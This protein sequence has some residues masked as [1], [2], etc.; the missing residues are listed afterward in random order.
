MSWLAV[1]RKDFQDSARS[2][3]LW[4]VLAVFVLFAGGIA[5]LYGEYLV[6][7]LSGGAPPAG[8]LTLGFVLLMSGNILGGV[9]PVL[10]LV[11]IIGL[12]LGYKSVV[13]ERETGQIKLLLG[14][15]HSRSDVVLGKL[16]G[17]TAVALL[18]VG[19]GFLVA[20][21]VV[22]IFGSFSPVVYLQF[23]VA[24]AIFAFVHVSIGVGI[25]SATSSSSLSILGIVA[26]VGIFQVVWGA[27]FTVGQFV[28][29]DIT[30]TAPDWYRFLRNVT[31]G[32]AYDGL[33]A[34]VVPRYAEAQA[35]AANNSPL[36]AAGDQ[37]FFLQDWFGVLLLVFWGTV[38]LAL[39][40][41]RFKSVDLG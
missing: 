5:F 34:T 25:S 10:V 16:A 19:V 40:Y 2:K 13:G 32:R 33:L 21:V 37:P 24:V 7:D 3:L 28:L 17:R 36:Q 23:V 27:A 39:G 14:L 15:P 22:A 26:F 38:P 31:P 41:L 20:A 11:P 9:G 1:A 18:G 29:F 35:E 12:L 4:A 30:E 8:D 6:G